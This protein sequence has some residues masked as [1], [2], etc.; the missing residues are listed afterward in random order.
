MRDELLAELHRR[1]TRFLSEGDPDM[2][3]SDDARH[4]AE[5]LFG[6]GSRPGVGP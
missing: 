6:D 1:A 5:R 2:V 3:L 4:R